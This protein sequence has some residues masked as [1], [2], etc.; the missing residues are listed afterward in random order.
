MAPLLQRMDKTGVEYRLI[1]SGQHADLTVSLRD[2]L[3]LRDPEVLLGGNCD[4]VSVSQALLWSL[5]IAKHFIL[6]PRLRQHIFGG[7]SG[8]C[9]VHGDTPTTLLSTLLAWRAGLAV[10]HVEAGLRTYRWFQPFPEEIIRVIVGRIADVLF[11]PSA[12]AAA[13][14]RR[15]GVKGQIIKQENNTVLESLRAAVKH[16]AETK[17]LETSPVIITMHRVENLHSRSRRQK[18]FDLARKLAQK[19]PVCWIVHSPTKRVIPK[20]TWKNLRAAGVQIV[21][22]LP[23][24]EFIALLVD[25]PLVV[26]DGGSIQE[27]CALIG[28]PTLLWRDCTDREDGLGQNIVLSRFDD[29]VIDEFLANYQVHRCQAVIPEVNPS[30]QIL[31]ELKKWQ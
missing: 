22:L 26:T 13:N 8:V 18:L 31:A 21:P 11:A 6:K 30:E 20:E 14:L 9:I 17:Q 16:H 19:M 15:S 24:A 5:G 12:T 2:E 23:H 4:V 28:V 1:D 27:E 3:G 25:A 10:A 7:E 29:I